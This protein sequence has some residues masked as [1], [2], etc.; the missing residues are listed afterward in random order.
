MLPVS[1]H[2]YGTPR[3]PRTAGTILTRRLQ[4]ALQAITCNA[5]LNALA[6]V[7]NVFQGVVDYKEA[8]DLLEAILGKLDQVLGH[9]RARALVTELLRPL[10]KSAVMACYAQLRCAFHRY[11]CNF[12]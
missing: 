5:V 3:A 8:A 2:P 9:A 1:H 4:I 10:V 6:K 7:I 12:H 11:L